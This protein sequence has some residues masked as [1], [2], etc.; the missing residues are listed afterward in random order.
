[1]PAW[2]PRARELTEALYQQH[3]EMTNGTDD[4][5]R[6][7]MKL[8]AEQ[9]AF[10]IDTRY[11]VKSAG[12]GRPQGPSQIA[13][14][15]PDHL[16]GWRV[17]DNDGSV[18]GTPNAPMPNPPW[19]SFL[20]QVF[21]AVVPTNHLGPLLPEPPPPPTP[22]PPPPPPPPP[23][24]DLSALL[25]RLDTLERDAVLTHQALE[26]VRYELSVLKSRQLYVYVGPLTLKCEP[27]RTPKKNPDF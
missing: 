16:G 11:G 25:L 22:K 1:M 14:N 17:L 5:R 6:A 23:A 12:P 8:L 4:T 13:F 20:G 27:E 7:F 10:S 19:Q 9:L 2:P 3:R 15:G 21:I 18:T 26:Q 24:V